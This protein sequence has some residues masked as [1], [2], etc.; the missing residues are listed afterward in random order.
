MAEVVIALLALVNHVATIAMK[1]EQAVSTVKRNRRRCEHLKRDAETIGE[2]LSELND[3]QKEEKEKPAT[4]ASKAT[5]SLLESL[6]KAINTGLELVESCGKRS[7]LNLFFHGQGLAGKLEDVHE[8]ISCCVRTLKLANLLVLSRIVKQLLE[9]IHRELRSN[10]AD[11]K[12]L[13][14]SLSNPSI[15]NTWSEDKKEVFIW[16]VSTEEK[17]YTKEAEELRTLAEEVVSKVHENRWLPVK[18]SAK[19]ILDF[20]QYLDD[21]GMKAQDVTSPGQLSRIK[22]VL[23]NAYDDFTR[24]SHGGGGGGATNFQYFLRSTKRIDEQIRSAQNDINLY[25]EQ[26]PTVRVLRNQISHLLSH[27]KKM[28]QE[29]SEIYRRTT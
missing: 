9:G 1:L 24:Y 3:M 10:S 17:S 5:R 22:R 11:A 18:R 21:L 26:L 29:L 6:E 19:Q 14:R 2:L 27:D 28:M 25:L 7:S 4:T 20:M 16:V 8:D 13:T 15:P 23:R 12:A